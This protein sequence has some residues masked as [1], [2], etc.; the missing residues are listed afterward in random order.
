MNIHRHLTGVICVLL[1]FLALSCV[2]DAYEKGQNENADCLGISFKN[3]QPNEGINYLSVD[4]AAELEFPVV[5]PSADGEAFCLVDLE[6]ND[7]E[8]L[9]RGLITVTPA[10]FKEGQT[11]SSVKVKFDKA[12]KSVLY[13]C[14]ISIS[15][16]TAALIYGQ[17]RLAV[18]F[19]FITVE[20][21]LVTGK[22]G[23]KTGKFRDGVISPCFG[24]SNGQ[25]YPE[26]DVE[27][28]QRKDKPGYFRIVNPYSP[29]LISLWATGSTGNASSFAS[30][31]T[32][33]DIIVDATENIS[34]E[35]FSAVMP[36][37]STGFNPSSSLGL[38]YICTTDDTGSYDRSTGIISIPQV[39]VSFANLNPGSPV[40]IP[41]K[42]R[43]VL[44]G[45][46]APD[47]SIVL[48]P[49]QSAFGNTGVMYE[50]GKDVRKIKYKFYRGRLDEGEIFVNEDNIRRGVES[51]VEEYDANV[52][53]LPVFFWGNQ[54]TP[55]DF[56]TLITITVDK[57]GNC[58]ESA[59]CSFGHVADGD[60]RTP[61]VSAELLLT[62]KHISQGYTKENSLEFS[63]Y[64][65]DAEF[66]MLAVVPSDKVRT[67]DAIY[68]YMDQHAYEMMLDDKTVNVMRTSGLTGFVTNLRSGTSYSLIVYVE[69][70]YTYKLIRTA[71]TTEG[72]KQID[73]AEDYFNY[74]Y[75]EQ[76]GY[77]K[78][79]LCSREWNMYAIPALSSYTSR[80]MMNRVTFEDTEDYTDLDGNILDMVTMK[81]MWKRWGLPSYETKFAYNNGMLISLV[82]VWDEPLRATDKNGMPIEMYLMSCYWTGNSYQNPQFVDGAMLGGNVG[83]GYLAMVSSPTALNQGYN[84]N[85]VLLMGFKTAEYKEAYGLVAGF[86]DILLSDATMYDV[87]DPTVDSAQAV[88]YGFLFGDWSGMSK[89]EYVQVGDR[90]TAAEIEAMQKEAAGAARPV[91]TFDNATSSSKEQRGEGLF[92]LKLEI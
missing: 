44:P 9:D 52:G 26:I 48:S 55:T 6:C 83:S 35:Q 30:M 28:Y 13:E 73:P 67:E 90:I 10:V 47:Y 20:W 24:E 38:M 45:F 39:G 2:K 77:T 66:V 42:T 34:G 41:G 69:N 43:I 19:S 22:S 46:E 15:D 88:D 78:E 85:T 89:P 51:G 37:Q 65:K 82:N 16:P 21:E 72:I 87:K 58:R 57:D 23:E 5:R 63:V 11:E 32:S 4:D 25:A 80:M 86:S 64:C 29:E 59:S 33:T 61:V 56:Y 53:E 50:V 18:D 71:M 3:S 14:R 75:F 31:C 54:S 92:I 74:A 12:A 1:S 8:A 62:N 60:D 84:I 49:G 79:Y 68:D 70:G 81:T 17:G 7:R 76:E 40:K 91:V 36:Y 27:I